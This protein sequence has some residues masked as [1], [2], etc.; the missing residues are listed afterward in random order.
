MIFWWLLEGNVNLI[1]VCEIV[2]DAV[3]CSDLGYLVKSESGPI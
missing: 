2:S 1:S 3:G